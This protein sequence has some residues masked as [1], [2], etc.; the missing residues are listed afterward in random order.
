MCIKMLLYGPH[1]AAVV[2]LC[3][4]W[5]F[6]RKS[7]VTALSAITG[8]K[9]SAA[10]AREKRRSLVFPVIVGVSPAMTTT[11]T[12]LLLL[13]LLLCITI[14]GVFGARAIPSAHHTHTHTVGHHRISTLLTHEGNGGNPL[15]HPPGQPVRPPARQALRSLNHRRP[16]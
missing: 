8:F 16:V 9:A 4:V 5:L 14:G 6:S 15:S 7:R 10:R 11:P 13:L 1:L 2:V 3:C 12:V